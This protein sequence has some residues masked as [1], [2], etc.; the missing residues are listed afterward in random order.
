MWGDLWR[1]FCCSALFHFI[2]SLLYLM[3]CPL[4]MELP[5]PFHSNWFENLRNA[6]PYALLLP[7]PSPHKVPLER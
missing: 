7:L 4:S 3:L 2:F 6:Q 5:L 1:H